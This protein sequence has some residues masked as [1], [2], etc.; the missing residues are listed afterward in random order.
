IVVV[1]VATIS[2]SIAAAVAAAA[3]SAAVIATSQSHCWFSVVAEQQHSKMFQWSQVLSNVSETVQTKHNSDVY[4]NH[5][6][7]VL[8]WYRSRCHIYEFFTCVIANK[9]HNP[10]GLDDVNDLSNDRVSI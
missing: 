7:H 4:E 3:A 8:E 2:S 1:V 5:H 9:I 10:N 6:P